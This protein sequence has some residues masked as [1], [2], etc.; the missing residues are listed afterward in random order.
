[1]K[2]VSVLQ[3]LDQR[4]AIA[5]QL[6]LPAIISLRTMSHQ[7]PQMIA[8]DARVDAPIQEEPPMK[9]LRGANLL[10]VCSLRN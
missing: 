10:L 9:R 1:M 2:Y 3:P 7:A 4:V 5:F 6:Y 8:I